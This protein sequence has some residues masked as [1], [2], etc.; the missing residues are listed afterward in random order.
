MD[1]FLGQVLMNVV[2]IVLNYVLSRF[3]VFEKVVF[4]GG[5]DKGN[6]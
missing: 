2:V 4:S 1:E 3:L 6:D 5:K